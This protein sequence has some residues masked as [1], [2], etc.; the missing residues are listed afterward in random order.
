MIKKSK[1]FLIHG[2]IY[3]K[4]DYFEQSD[5]INESRCYVEE[6]WAELFPDEKMI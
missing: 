5:V 6:K 3:Y 2:L 1:V 4:T